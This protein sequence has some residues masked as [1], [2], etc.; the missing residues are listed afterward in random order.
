ML[1]LIIFYLIVIE[2]L[3]FFSGQRSQFIM[4]FFLVLGI[5][6]INVRRVGRVQLVAKDSDLVVTV[7][8]TMVSIYA[9][10]LCC[11]VMITSF[12]HI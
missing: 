10:M 6:L 3:I 4:S 5:F 11:F 12:F 8:P 1:N 2:P 7:P 9:C